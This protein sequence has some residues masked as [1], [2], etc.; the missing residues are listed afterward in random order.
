MNTYLIG[1]LFV[2]LTAAAAAAKLVPG[3][4]PAS[5]A[6]FTSHVDLWA[7]RIETSVRELESELSPLCVDDVK[8]FVNA[9]SR[10]E[11]WA[12][13]SEYARFSFLF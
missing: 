5:D 9:T 2:S 4:N 12:F 11:H 6:F 1:A 10:R 3:G 13:K 7:A 8:K